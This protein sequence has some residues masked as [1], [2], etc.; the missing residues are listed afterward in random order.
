M[1]NGIKDFG[2]EEPAGWGG[3]AAVFPLAGRENAGNRVEG[4]FFG[5]DVNERAREI[6][7]H[8]VEEPVA[9]DGDLKPVLGKVFEGDFF[10][11]AERVFFRLVGKGGK[12][13][14]AQEG[15]GRSFHKGEIERVAVVPGV[16]A[17]EG[18]LDRA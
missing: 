4:E 7:D 1:E 17:V 14:R 8:F 9:L 5:S 10:K 18:V 15:L 13:V 16:E 11:S 3:G 6:A 2:E 12:V